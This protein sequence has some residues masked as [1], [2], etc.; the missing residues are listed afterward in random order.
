MKYGNGKSII[1]KSMYDFLYMLF[2]MCM[3]HSVTLRI[4]SRR[5]AIL[6]I[7]LKVFSLVFSLETNGKFSFRELTYSQTIGY[8][9]CSAYRCV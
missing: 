5:L 6:S 2:C 3:C 4:I 1:Y 7:S 9:L 8:F